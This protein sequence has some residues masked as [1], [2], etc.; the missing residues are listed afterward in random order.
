ME[1]REE[2][3]WENVENFNG[4]VMTT[5]QAKLLTFLVNLEPKM[6]GIMKQVQEFIREAMFGT[7]IMSYKL[8]QLTNLT[9]FLLLVT[10]HLGD[11][12]TARQF[13]YD[14]LFFRNTRAHCML[15]V[16]LDTWH[17]LFLYPSSPNILFETVI[18]VIFNS[19]PSQSCTDMKVPEV[20]QKLNSWGI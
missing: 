12:K 14:T 6:P 15:T 7:G 9:R 4:P 3:E 20:K 17:E 16:L 5:K 18:W 8:F 2:K 10:R 19:G 11:E 1:V 13:I